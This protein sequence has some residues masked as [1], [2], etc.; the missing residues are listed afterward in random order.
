MRLANCSADVTTRDLKFASP[1]SSPIRG[2]VLIK[3]NIYS[4]AGGSSNSKYNL[5]WRNLCY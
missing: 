1:A 3:L 2:S 5:C 4:R